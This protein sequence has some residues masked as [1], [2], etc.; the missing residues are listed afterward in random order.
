MPSA[1]MVG[2]AQAMAESGDH[3]GVIATLA[4][5]PLERL[6]TDGKRM[7]AQAYARTDQRGEARRV[8][9]ALAESPSAVPSDHFEL[10]VL[11]A[12][13]QRWGLAIESLERAESQGLSGVR[14]HEELALAHAAI[15]NHRGTPLLR[16]VV[17]AAPGQLC[18]EGYVWKAAAPPQEGY[19]I[20]PK[21][22]AIYHVV[23]ARQL[24]A[25]SP[26]LER[27]R[28]DIFSE[29]GD[30]AVALAIYRSIEPR[31]PG[32]QQAE[33]CARFAELLLACGDV[34]G[35]VQKLRE[36]A[37]RDRHRYGPTL[38]AAYGRAAAERS[39]A[40]DLDG[41]IRNLKLAIESSPGSAELH[42]RLGNALWEAGQLAEAAGQWL[43]VIELDPQHPDRE[44]LLELV[45]ELSIA[46]DATSADEHPLARQP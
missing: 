26:Q 6:A 16:R 43:T 33:F 9:Q 44:R 37:R 27:I 25:D 20:C 29:S 7:L 36:A 41:Y 22:S 10:G 38:A 46:Q 31:I 17:D 40:G 39:M 19:L 30:L 15:G 13:D 18:D 28:A 14:L 1:D 32:D 2:R 11:Y 35:Y 24:G 8:Y 23:R 12:R 34:D 5:I 45:R 21:A 42:Y 4:T 3:A